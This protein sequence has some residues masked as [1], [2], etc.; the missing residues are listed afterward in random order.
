MVILTIIDRFSKMVHLVALDSLPSAE[1][2]GNI[3]IQEVFRLQGI[4]KNIVSD[5]GPQ[6]ISKFWNEF[7][8]DVEIS[9][10]SGYHLQ[11]DSQTER[12]NQ[13]METRL[14]LLCVGVMAPNG[15][16]IYPSLNTPSTLLLP[17]PLVYH[18]S[19]CSMDFSHRCSPHKK[20]QPWSHLLSKPP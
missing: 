8:M 6:F 20:E 9:L 3:M 5:R 15:L 4:P 18:H 1:Q 12:A 13:E 2:L 17:A 14:R 19:M 11:T 7:C 16:S 10:S